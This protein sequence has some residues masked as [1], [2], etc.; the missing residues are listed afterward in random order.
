MA[1]GAVARLIEHLLFGIEPLDLWTFAA[2]ALVLVVIATVASYLPARR[3]MK[4]APRDAL[5]TN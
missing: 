2:S 4:L 3:G 5:R 1:A